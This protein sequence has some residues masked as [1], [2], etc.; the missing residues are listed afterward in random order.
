MHTII[1]TYT[2]KQAWN[3]L[4]TSKKAMD[5]KRIFAL[6]Y[7]TVYQTHFGAVDAGANVVDAVHWLKKSVKSKD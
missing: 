5:L 3:P 4:I 7:G 6:V 1:M 2:T